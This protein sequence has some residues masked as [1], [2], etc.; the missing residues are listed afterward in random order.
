MIVPAKQG[1]SIPQGRLQVRAA[2]RLVPLIWI[3]SL[4]VMPDVTAAPRNEPGGGTA[5]KN[6]L[7]VAAISSI[8]LPRQTAAN[9]DRHVFW[10]ER[11]V[12]QGARFVGFPECSITGYEF[13]ENAGI[14]LESAEVL[15]LVE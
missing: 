7:R 11:A 12:A 2:G 3:L 8:C 14:S 10:T 6:T 5:E 1:V 13:S 15:T 4:L 9:L